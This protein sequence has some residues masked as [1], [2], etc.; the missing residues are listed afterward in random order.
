M[1]Q[2][3]KIAPGKSQYLDVKMKSDVKMLNEVVITPGKK[4]RY[5]NKN[6][7]AVELIGN[8]IDHK[9]MNE[10]KN[11]DYI[12]Y[13]KYEKNIFALSNITDNLKKKNI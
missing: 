2:I 10:S 11:Y 6:N 8:V 1:P 7:S 5:R 12:E 4:K 13:E 9:S 3:I